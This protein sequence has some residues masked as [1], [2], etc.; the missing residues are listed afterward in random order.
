MPAGKPEFPERCTRTALKETPRRKARH[1]PGDMAI[2]LD[3][4]HLSVSAHG[5]AKWVF[6]TM[7]LLTIAF[8]LARLASH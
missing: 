5:P 4:R 6:A 7:V 1:R 2:G 8:L 3:L